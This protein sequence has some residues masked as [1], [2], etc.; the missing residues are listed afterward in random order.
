M[1]KW[2]K[3]LQKLKKLS[4]DL[5]FAELQ[6]IL[7]NYGYTLEAPKSGSSHMSFRKKGKPVITI[8]KHKPIKKIYIKLA[9]DVIEREEEE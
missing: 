1:S 4:P 8:P 3:L 7:E 2:E 5:R 9:K 6:K